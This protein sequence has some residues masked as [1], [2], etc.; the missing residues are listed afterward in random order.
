MTATG[1]FSYDLNGLSPNTLYYFKPK[2]PATALLKAVSYHLPLPRLRHTANHNHSA[3]DQYH[4]HHCQIEWHPGW[5]GYSFLRRCLLPLAN[6]YRQLYGTLAQSMTATGDFS[7]DLSSLTPATTYYFKA[8]AVG[9]GITEGN[10]LTS[11]PLRY[12]PYLRRNHSAGDQ[13]YHYHRPFKRYPGWFGY[14]LC[15]R[16]LLPLADG[17]RQLYGNTSTVYDGYRRLLFRSL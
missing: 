2:P 10:E 5:F 14:S 11:L 17:Y 6:G 16:C 15:R 7:F 8:K 3:G 12:R 1:D 4:L 13:H 9:D